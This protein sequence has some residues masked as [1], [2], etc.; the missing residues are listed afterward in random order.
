MEKY[1]SNL[2]LVFCATTVEKLIEPIKSRCMM[3]RVPGLDY[4]S[5]NHLISSATPSFKLS[6]DNMLGISS[7][8]DGNGRK[9]LLMTEAVIQKY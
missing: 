8:C 5:V 2:R 6:E 1:S 3:I 9:A 4:E 7:K